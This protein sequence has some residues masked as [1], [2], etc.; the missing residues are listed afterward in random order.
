MIPESL[1]EQVEELLNQAV[2]NIRPISGGSINQAAKITTGDNQ[3]FFLKWNASAASDMF[4][5]EEK[6]LSLLYSAKSGLLVPEIIGSGSTRENID[7]LVIEFIPQ[8]SANT[9]SAQQ[10]GRR[11]AALHKNTADHYG[12]EHDNYI[13]KLPQSNTQHGNW[14]EFF[15]EERLQ[16]QL[17]AAIKNGKFSSS[18]T[19]NFEQLY[20]QLPDSLADEPPSLLHG[21]LWGGNYFYDDKGKP[22]IFDPAVYY[23]N[24]EIE[25]AFTHLFGGF[26]SGFYE[27]YKQAFPMQPN[28]NERKDIYNLY[29]LLVHTNLFGGSYA[30][31]VK[32]IVKRF[33]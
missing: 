19:K 33:A 8:G 22:V 1:N 18:I 5:K 6:G 16:P 3:T 2:K 13:G 14:T 15:V 17:R 28:F 10:F 25:I 7:F 21:D 23:G 20:N 31:Q 11:L 4:P 12:L 29:P 32:K 27:A 24:R 30:R 9:D 26:S